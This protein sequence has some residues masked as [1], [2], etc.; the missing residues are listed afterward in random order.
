MNGHE[1]TGLGDAVNDIN[2]IPLADLSLVL[3][4]ILMVLSPMILQSLIKINATQAAAVAASAAQAPTEP[5]LMVVVDPIG[6]T[7]NTVRIASLP[8]F[9][10][11]LRAALGQRSNKTVVL[12][13]DPQ[14][15]HGRVVQILDAIK[16][17]GAGKVALLKK[18][19]PKNG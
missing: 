10:E 6:I 3:L 7:L 19:T 1:A 17:Q 5:P 14:V 18:A 2:V 16:Q 4:I 12:T 11:R 15:L 8:E 13:A 9:A